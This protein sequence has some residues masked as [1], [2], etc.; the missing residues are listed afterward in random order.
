MV[1]RVDVAM[2][3]AEV[4]NQERLLIGEV[5]ARSRELITLREQL[6]ANQDIQ[7]IIRKL[8]EVSE[9]RLK[10]AEVSVADVNL[11]KLE[12]QK[13]LLAGAGLLNQQDIATV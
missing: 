11:A 6:K 12:L 2:A 5:L 9:K 1:A 7:D 8:I 3:V 4:R 10:V 13:L